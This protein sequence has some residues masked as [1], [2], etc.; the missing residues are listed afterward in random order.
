M[1]PSDQMLWGN[2]EVANPGRLSGWAQDKSR[3][4]SAVD[5]LITNNGVEVASI[6]ADRH[7]TD[8]AQA[9]IGDGNHAFEYEFSSGDISTELH[10]IRIFERSSCVEVPGSPVT[11]KASQSFE[12]VA[13][14]LVGSLDT[15]SLGKI[16][17]WARDELRPEKVITLSIFD[18][19]EPIGQVVANAYR[20]DLKTAGLGGGCH[21]FEF[22]ASLDPSREHVIRVRRGAN[23]V[24][25]PGSPMTFSPTNRAE[26]VANSLNGSIDSCHSLRVTGWARD[27]LE[28]DAAVSLLIT[29]NDKLV[30]RL[31]ANGYREDLK[32]AGIGDGRFAFEFS[33]PQP[34]APFETHIIR[35]FSEADGVDVPGSPVTLQAS[36]AFDAEVERSLER[37][38]DRCGTTDDIPAKIDFL[39]RQIDRL[40][41][42]RADADSTRVDRERYRDLLQRWKSQPSRNETVAETEI[43]PGSAPRALVIDDRLPKSDRDAG[44]TAVLS[45]IRSLQRLGYRVTFVPAIEFNPAAADRAAIEAFDVSCG[46]APYYGTVEEVLKRQAG[47]FD[48]VYLH[49]ISNASKYGELVLNYFPKARRIYSVA[50]LHHVRLLRQSQVEDRPELEALSKRLQLAEF[51]AAA[52]SNAVITHSKDETDLLKS[53]LPG[54]A[55]FTLPWSVK[56]RP[57]KVPF[58][59]RA[60]FAFIGGFGHMP[61]QDAVRW[62][63][64]DIMP[65]VRSQ[66]P[67]IQCFLVGSDM[68]EQFK[69]LQADGIVPIGYVE[70]LTEIFDRVRLTVAPLAYGAG[71]KGKVIDSLSAGIPCV[72]TN[73]AAEGLNLPAP[74]RACVADDPE[75]FAASIV[76]LHNSEAENDRCGRA[77]LEFVDVEFSDSYLDARMSE[78]TGRA[79]RNPAGHTATT[80]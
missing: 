40:L 42:R 64:K 29:N 58:S 68:P 38:L 59:Q 13:K 79:G 72:C 24:E 2:I 16:T 14:A 33:F 45:H 74:L 7:R 55:V 11:L 17:G 18:N 25:I 70:D 44:S 50:D 75:G 69:Q 61:N 65:L 12:N 34:L 53:R 46:C 41:Q 28:P 57:T 27:H 76:C 66:D 60:G 21:A 30:G 15:V 9:G 8:L 47:E 4:D 3:P 63:I 62:L 20:E 78:V 80:T 35:V 36:Q 1:I 23:G 32:T 48:L 52:F 71:L 19:D 5:L 51:T 26:T 56:S 39:A 43:A 77:G 73:I 6:L 49:R 67:S 54:A 31:L 37:V 22:A 10:V